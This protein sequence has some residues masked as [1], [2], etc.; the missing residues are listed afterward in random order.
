MGHFPDNMAA[1]KN[2]DLIA[3]QILDLAPSCVEFVPG[4]DGYFIIGTYNLQKENVSQEVE[5]S[6][7]VAVSRFHTGLKPLAQ[8]SMQKCFKSS[9]TVI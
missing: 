3:S 6:G 9:G 2:M 7:T 8:L 1:T 4:A 5:H